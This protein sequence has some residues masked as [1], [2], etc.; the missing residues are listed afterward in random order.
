MGGKVVHAP[1]PM[2]G[3]EQS[4]RHT[5]KGLF[6]NMPDPFTVIRYHS[7]IVAEPLARLL[8]QDR[9]DARRPGYG[10]GSQD[11]SDVGSSISSRI[12]LHGPYGRQLMENF[13]RMAREFHGSAVRL[14]AEPNYGIQRGRINVQNRRAEPKLCT[15]LSGS[16]GH[17]IQPNK[18]LNARSQTR[19][20]P[21]GWTAVWRAEGDGRFS[22]L[23]GCTARTVECVRYY[24]HQRRLTTQSMTAF[25]N[26]RTEELFP[27]LKRRIASAH[28]IGPNFP[29]ISTG[30]LSA[31]LAMN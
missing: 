11:P 30:A 16:F 31:T 2:H 8:R 7:L 25:R 14:F 27:Y 28:R 3:R 13:Y 18:Y 10:S 26:W 15:L 6:E 20:M 21:F 22:F 29:S 24:A 5:G 1:Q 9:L 23:G 19:A 12:H 17:S 4:I